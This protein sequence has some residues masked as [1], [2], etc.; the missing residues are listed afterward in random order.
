MPCHRARD[1]GPI[2]LLNRTKPSND[3]TVT[4]AALP[5]DRA[6]VR[7]AVGDAVERLEIIRKAT[8]LIRSLSFRGGGAAADDDLIEM[9]GSL[10]IR[11]GKPAPGGGLEAGEQRMVR[12]EGFPGL[13]SESQGVLAV[14]EALLVFR[15]VAADP[16]HLVGATIRKLSFSRIEPEWSR[17]VSEVG[18]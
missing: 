13:P 12:G 17:S 1:G 16:Q 18:P 10:G 7:V 5:S 2:G 9:V 15:A 4:A 3:L 6:A 11:V 8:F 14:V